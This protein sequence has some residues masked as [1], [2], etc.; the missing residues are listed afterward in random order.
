MV[1]ILFS[2]FLSFLLLTLSACP[3]GTQ[4]SDGSGSGGSEEVGLKNLDFGE[5]QTVDA[6]DVS[7]NAHILVLG[8]FN[9]DQKADA[10]VG[11]A[12]I[13]VY[14]GKGDGSFENPTDNT[15]DGMPNALTSGDLGA[16]PQMELAAATSNNKASILVDP[17]GD[18]VFDPADNQPGGT[19]PRGIAIADFDGDGKGD[20]ATVKGGDNGILVKFGA[21]DISFPQNVDFSSGGKINGPRNMV[22]TDFNQDG[23]P[24]LAIV[25]F[26]T[27]RVVLWR[28]SG[29]PDPT[30]VFPT[31]NIDDSLELPPGASAQ[32]ILAA[33]L[34]GDGMMDLVVPN[35]ATKNVSVFINQ[36]AAVFGTASLLPAGFDAFAA[37]TGDFNLD[38]KQDLAV[39]NAFGEDGSQGNVGVYLGNGDGSFAAPKFFSTGTNAGNANNDARSIGAAD[40]NGD[41]KPDLITAN[42]LAK[43]L[44]ILL[45]TSN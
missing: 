4:M 30:Q 24:D 39:C 26:G 41:G 5:P 36:G 25:S 45:N 43:T 31:G 17:D 14:L 27:D 40:F 37:V 32:G 19:Q 34:N 33:D 2:V 16:G 42:S 3:S 7:N 21:G 12:G 38:G 10:A 1:N 20:L 18:G 11:N 23:K 9:S 28:N 44:T 35:P 13:R 29:D 8:D 15:T 6:G 22:A